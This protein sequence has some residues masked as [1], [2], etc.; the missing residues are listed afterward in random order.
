MSATNTCSAVTLAKLFGITE[1]WVQQLAQEGILVRGT[2]RGQYDLVGSVRGYVSHL[3]ARLTQRVEREDTSLQA[4]RKRL[5]GLQADKTECELSILRDEWVAKGALEET[6]A[7]IT[8]CYV[9]GLASLPG[10]L[11][12]ELVNQPDAAVVRQ[13]IL[14]ECQQVREA[15]YK[16]LMKKGAFYEKQAS[17]PVSSGKGREAILDP[18]SECLGG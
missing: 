14:H 11:A 6:V 8:Q 18:E 15:L 4:E 17:T 9:Q 3:Q 12:V 5:L 16:Q 7:E 2:S 10:R 1:R 13:K